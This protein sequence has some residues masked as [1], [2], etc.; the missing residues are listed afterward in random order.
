[1]WRNYILIVENEEESFKLPYNTQPRWNCNE[2]CLYK[3][4]NCPKEIED[5]DKFIRDHERCCE[6]RSKLK[7]KILFHYDSNLEIWPLPLVPKIND[8]L[9]QDPPSGTR[10]DQK[11]KFLEWIIK[12]NDPRRHALILPNITAVRE[13]ETEEIYF[14]KDFTTI[15]ATHL[16]FDFNEPPQKE[17]VK[18]RA[19]YSPGQKQLISCCRLRR[20]KSRID[21]GSLGERHVRDYIFDQL[22]NCKRRR[23]MQSLEEKAA[24]TIK[25]YNLTRLIPPHLKPDLMYNFCIFGHFGIWL[26]KSI[27]NCDIP[28]VY[29]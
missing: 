9:L 6:K 16:L 4:L 25:M 2:M 29:V 11:S 24:V 10:V 15:D 12:A 5:L 7:A 3:K 21:E 22:K 20:Y 17:I 14:G 18:T 13:V 19:R 8:K 1:M 23:R 28:I 27:N 26:R